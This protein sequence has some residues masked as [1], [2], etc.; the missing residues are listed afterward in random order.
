MSPQGIQT[1]FKLW[2]ERRAYIQATAGTCGL[3]LSQGS[4]VSIPLEAANSGSLSHTYCCGKPPLEVLVE[5]WLTSSVEARKSALILRRYGVHGAFL[6]FLC[7]NWCSS[8]LETGVSGNLW[9]C[10]K[11]VKPLVMYD[12]EQGMALEPIQGNRGSS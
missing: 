7:W 9:S 8:R 6:E 5:R 12:V 1:S 3:L 11:E 2:D 10:L 4:S